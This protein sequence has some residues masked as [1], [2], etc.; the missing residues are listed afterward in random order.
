MVGP[1]RIRDK[2]APPGVG[3]L[4]QIKR[5]PHGTGAARRRNR[6]HLI[7][8]NRIA[9]NERDHRIGKGWLTGKGGIGLGGLCLPELFF[10]SL[11]RAH[12]RGHALGGFVDTDAKVDL[13]LARVFAE[14]LTKGQNL[15]SG[16]FFQ[17]VKHQTS[18]VATGR[19]GKAP[20]SVQDPS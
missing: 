7:A 10:R 14:R 6:R 1:C 8:R 16:F 19:V 17:G 18:P 11:D 9:Q 12:D 3:H 15:V 13:G 5:L 20:H 4:D 2:D